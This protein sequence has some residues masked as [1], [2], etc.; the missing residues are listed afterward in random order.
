MT[1]QLDLFDN[2][3]PPLEEI[4]ELYGRSH[5]IEHDLPIIQ[6]ENARSLRWLFSLKNGLS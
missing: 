3:D 6:E 1:Q 5:I 4:I 2:C